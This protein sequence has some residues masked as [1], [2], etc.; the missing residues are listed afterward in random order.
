[1]LLLSCSQMKVSQILRLTNASQI[2]LV[3]LLI[4]VMRTQFRVIRIPVVLLLQQPVAMDQ[5]PALQT[6]SSN[7]RN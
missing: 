5:C 3:T 1:M 4:S 6:V 2:V 7:V